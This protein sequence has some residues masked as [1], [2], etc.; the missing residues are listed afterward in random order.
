MLILPFLIST[1]LISNHNDDINV[2]GFPHIIL[3]KQFVPISRRPF[4][5]CVVSTSGGSDR[6]NATETIHSQ[7]PNKCFGY[8]VVF[9]VVASRTSSC[10]K[11]RNTRN[12]Y[13]LSASTKA[14]AQSTK[15]SARLLSACAERYANTF[16]SYSTSLLISELHRPHDVCVRD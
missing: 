2:H 14:L 6:R 13:R 9:L 3:S 10:L 5:D 12:T 1:K 15:H 11:S 16:I 7:C 8:V 4:R